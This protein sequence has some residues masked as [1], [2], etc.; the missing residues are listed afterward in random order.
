MDFVHVNS[1]NLSKIGFNPDSQELTVIFNSGGVYTYSNVSAILYND[2][3]TAPSLGKYFSA[4]IK[5][6]PWRKGY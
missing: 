2:L 1:I 5:N 6:K 3:M 4:Y